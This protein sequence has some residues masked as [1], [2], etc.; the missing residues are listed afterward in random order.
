MEI[1]K[2]GA[3]LAN[4]RDAGETSA[5]ATDSSAHAVKVFSEHLVGKPL[6][7]STKALRGAYRFALAFSNPKP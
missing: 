6:D 7:K 5:V 3:R 4:Q 1:S 2:T